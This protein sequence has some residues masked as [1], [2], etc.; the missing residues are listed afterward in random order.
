MHDN[1]SVISA[2]DPKRP[3]LTLRQR[4]HHF[5]W[6]WWTMIMSTGGLSLLIF[7]QP[8]QFPGLRQIGLVVYIINLILFLTVFTSLTARFFLFSG[9]FKQ[10]IT[11]EREG[12]FL[13][14]FFLAIATLITSTYRYA[15]PPDDEQ[16]NWGVQIAFWSYM[17][18]TI[19]LAIGQ[20]SYVFRTHNLEVKTMMP[21]WILPIFPIML[22]GTIASVIAETQPA[23]ISTAIV[24]GGLA[25]QGLGVSVSFLMYAHMVGRLMSFGLPDREHRPGLFMNVGP[26]SFT[27]LALIGMAQGL[28]SDFDIDSNGVVD[29]HSIRSAAVLAGVFLWGLSLWWWGVAFIA[30]V[31]SRPKY[32]HLGWW[33]S[34]FPN[35]GFTLATI[36]I[37]KCINSNAVLGFAVFMS[38]CLVLTYFF[39]LYHNVRAVIKQEIMYPGRDEDVVDH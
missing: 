25:A 37:G 15:V 9:S 10:S 2:Y 7:A 28:P 18:V 16:L 5:T 4:L 12:F 21:T 38:V 32:F 14:T 27:C 1:D 11:H 8:F 35:T 6:A 31:S 20:Y 34:V 23:G 17:A 33:A 13:P 3:K 29:I 26:P 39:V 22:S 36:S 24:L 30:V 19:L